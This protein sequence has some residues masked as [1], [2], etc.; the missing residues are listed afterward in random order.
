MLKIETVVRKWG[1]S[2]GIILPKEIV[3]RESIREGN[4]INLNITPNNTTT[5]ADLFAL[6]KK[7]RLPK[8][9]KSTQKIM[10]EVDRQLWPE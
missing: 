8:L 4:E 3:D 6:S 7:M 2:L 1:N 9:K 5:V 10:R